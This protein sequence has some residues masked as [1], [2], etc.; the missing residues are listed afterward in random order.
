MSPQNQWKGKL[1]HRGKSCRQIL[2]GQVSRQKGPHSTF[3][4]SSAQPDEVPRSSQT[5]SNVDLNAQIHGADDV[6]VHVS[7]A[8][9]R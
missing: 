5:K 4:W 9:R 7:T 1:S 2:G 8:N 6:V 3:S